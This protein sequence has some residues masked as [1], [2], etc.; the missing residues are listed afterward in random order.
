MPFDI[1]EE[2]SDGVLVGNCAWSCSN[3]LLFNASFFGVSDITVVSE[4]IVYR[5][6]QFLVR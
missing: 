2:G 4:G 3:R 1:G 6:T 5:Q